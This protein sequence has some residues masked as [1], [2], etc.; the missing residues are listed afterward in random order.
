MSSRFGALKSRTSPYNSQEPPLHQS[1]TRPRD[2]ITA[3]F[4]LVAND[5]KVSGDKIR[6][7]ANAIRKRFISHHPIYGGVILKSNRAGLEA[8]IVELEKL[9]E[10]QKNTV[11]KR[12]GD[13]ARKSIEE[14]VK[15]AVLWA[16]LF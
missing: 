3:A 16:T 7:K 8:E 11:L 14:F 10:I 9:V 13:D 2:R 5:S 12:F 15:A 6:E 1:V 4:K